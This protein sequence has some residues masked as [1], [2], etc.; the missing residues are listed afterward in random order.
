VGW[1]HVGQ[2]PNRPRGCA[3]S[4]A[5][6][7]LQQRRRW[8]TRQRRCLDL[9]PTR[10]LTLGQQLVIAIGGMCRGG[11]GATPGFVWE[12]RHGGRPPG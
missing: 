9:I 8:L 2:R 4:S 3:I 5:L 12:A 1:I 11:R 7:T 6:A 10:R